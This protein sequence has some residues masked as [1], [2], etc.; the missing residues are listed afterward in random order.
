MVEIDEL[1]KMANK[2]RIE[3]IRSTTIAGSGHPTSCMSI[4]E[5]MSCL[6]FAELGPED[7]FILS[8]GHAVYKKRHQ[9][10]GYRYVFAPAL[11]LRNASLECQGL[12]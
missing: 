2:L 11:R 9:Y 10:Q 6:F 5:I 7:E 12:Q 8:K 4:A 1:A 3:S